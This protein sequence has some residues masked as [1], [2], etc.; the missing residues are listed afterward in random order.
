MS[1]NIFG[2]IQKMVWVM[3]GLQLLKI[4]EF[5]SFLNIFSWLDLLYLLE[6]AKELIMEGSYG[7]IR[8]FSYFILLI[9]VHKINI[10]AKIQ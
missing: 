2:L 9:T 6:F 8:L 1:Y 5:K 3:V 10:T 4:C 7:F